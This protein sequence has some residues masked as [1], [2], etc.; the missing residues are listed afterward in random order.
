MGST[1]GNT[2]EH[3]AS[4]IGEVFEELM[5]VDEIRA[6]YRIFDDIAIDPYAGTLKIQD[7]IL[8]PGL[9]IT[10]QIREAEKVALFVCTAGPT[11]SVLSRCHT[12]DSDL[13]RAYI[14][15][16]TGTLVV[17]KTADMILHELRQ[18]MEAGGSGITNRFSPGCCGWD[19]AEQHK[20]FSLLSDNHCGVTL[21][22]S[23]LMNPVKSL[24]GIIAIGRNVN[25]KPWQCHFCND[26]NCIY[27]GRKYEGQDF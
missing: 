23:A 20:L 5:D 3:L 21:T 17:E 27:R 15:D 13:I 6:E 18:T 4:L 24:D 2:P 1:E 22:A 16:V 19:L 7:V 12:R 10:G 25:F 11:V 9:N 8:T 26:E 14:H